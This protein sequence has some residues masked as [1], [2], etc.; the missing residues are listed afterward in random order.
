MYRC[1]CYLILG[2]RSRLFTFYCLDLLFAHERCRF[3]FRFIFVV[4]F[5]FLPYTLVSDN[6][7]CFSVFQPDEML[8]HR[9]R[10]S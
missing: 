9:N 7:F 8:R 4:F 5:K 10:G 2:I 3:A 1:S 6:R